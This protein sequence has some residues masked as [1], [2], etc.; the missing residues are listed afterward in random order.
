MESVISHLIQ[1]EGYDYFLVGSYGQ[2]DRLAASVCLSLKSENPSIK[3]SLVIPYY[4][5][6]LDNCEKRYRAQFDAVIIPALEGIPY[7]YRILRA[8]EYMVDCADTVIAYV[9]TP[10]GGAAKTLAYAKHRG[11]RIIKV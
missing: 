6:K 3:V 11:K 4:R 2:F 1:D 5:P 8:N 9:N 10:A 7:Q